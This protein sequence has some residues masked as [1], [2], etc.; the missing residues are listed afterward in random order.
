MTMMTM[1][2]DGSVQIFSLARLAIYLS[3][4]QCAYLLTSVLTC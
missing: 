2:N 3:N 4:N 1:C